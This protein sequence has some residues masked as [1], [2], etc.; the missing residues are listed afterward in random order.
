MVEHKFDSEY[1]CDWYST[2][3]RV[4]DPIPSHCDTCA[5]GG[6]LLGMIDSNNSAIGDVLALCLGYLLLCYEGNGLGGCGEAPNLHAKR[7]APNVFVLGVL[8]Q[9][10]I[11]QEVTSL[12]VKYR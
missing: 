6:V 7:F 8:Q 5:G 3:V 11:L 10:A 4:V 1:V 12:I 9:M 2:F